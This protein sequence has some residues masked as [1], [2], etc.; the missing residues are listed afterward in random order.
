MHRDNR[1]AYWRANLRLVAICLTIWFVCSY[2]FGVLF[3]EQYL[4]LQIGGFDEVPV[5][6]YQVPDAGPGQRIGGR[7]SQCPAAQHGGGGT[8]Q[9]LL[10]LLPEAGQQ[11]LPMVARK[12]LPGCAGRILGHQRSLDG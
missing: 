9:C 4:P 2:G 8:A 11:H 6:D 7:C 5:D 12:I 3:V 10:R 1:L